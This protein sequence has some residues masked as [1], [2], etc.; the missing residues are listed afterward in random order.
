MMR[1]REFIALIGSAAAGWPV[2]ARAQQA[3]MPVIAFL[4]GG[5]AD[6]AA[7]NAAAFRKGL[8]EVG[9]EERSVTVEYHW[10]EGEYYRVPA[11]LADLIRRNVTVIA[12]PGFPPGALAAKAATTKIPVVFGVGDDPVKLGLVASVARPGGNVTGI[13]FFVHE[14]VSKRLALLHELVP[15]AVRVA[16]LVNPG[17]AS[18]AEATLKEAHEV[19]PALGLQ[20][21]AFN[22]GT[23]G[24]IDA[25]F[26][27][28][29]RERGDALLVGGDGF[30][31]TRRGQV[32][33]LTARDRL[34]SVSAVREF[35]EAGGLMTYG[36]KLTDM[37]RQVG[38]YAGSIVKGT[39]PSDLPVLQSTKFELVI[40]LQTA[41][42]LGL[43]VPPTLLARADEVIE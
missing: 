9:L 24:E 5:S 43:D 29:V 27:G 19:A 40:N 15:K 21:V 13:N 32:A 18:A 2:A 42:A 22:A 37:F 20:I 35:A 1:R 6:S 4:N 28:I 26:A 31:F 33:T 30:F 16:V 17:N 25:A 39:K 41:R 36:T 3:A 12:T 23:A 34:P 38:V 14:T 11:L 10:M 8:S 7:R